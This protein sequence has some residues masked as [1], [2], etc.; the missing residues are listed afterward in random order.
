M[1]RIQP[2]ERHVSD[3]NSAA[4]I[5]SGVE[6]CDSNYGISQS[7]LQKQSRVHFVDYVLVTS[8]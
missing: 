6:I 5:G 1:K 4:V 3:A 7:T 2:S 8:R